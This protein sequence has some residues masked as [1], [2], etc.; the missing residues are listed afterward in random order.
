MSLELKPA[1]PRQ[2]FLST[3][4]VIAILAFVKFA[5]HLITADR[6]G[7]FRDEL[8][9][10]ACADHLSWGYVDHP[11]LI[12]FV[13]WFSAHVFGTSLLGIRFL[14]AVAGGL[15]VW[16]T[17]A[18]AK[19]LGGNRFA[20]CFAAFA[21]IP[22]PI[23]LMLNHWL[24]MNAFEPLVWMTMLWLA[25]RM[26]SRNEP[27]Y[28]LLI[29]ALCGLGLENK[30]SMLL[31][32]AALVFGL[33]VTPE[34]QIFRSRWFPVGAAV[35]F[36]LFL[37]NLLW[38]IHHDFPFLEFERRSRMSLG[39]IERAPLAFIADQA[40]MMN[41]LLTP[42]WLGG[43]SWLLLSKPASKYRFLAWTFISIFAV[44]LVLKAKNYYV[45]PAYPV[46]FAAGAVAFEKTTEVAARWVRGI[47]VGLVL[48]AGSVL[49]PFVLPVLPVNDF[50]AYQRVFGG[51][52]PIR[53]EKNS[54]SLLPQQFADEFGWEEMVR[55]TAL[56]PISKLHTEAD[57]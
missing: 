54:R 44:L 29:G 11:P 22:A 53:L 46:L 10:L 8:Y 9:Y 21:I 39:R 40:L 41:P 17:A 13:T 19:E 16:V 52:T 5:L 6:Y 3:P 50:L 7:I 27:R 47:Y 12:A 26:L 51:F 31:L 33:F 34:R 45:S 4:A 30:Y 23:Y 48:A 28:W 15:L 1:D 56:E 37:P 24:T 32:A 25:L 14:P 36:V 35:A 20:Q 49:A 42:L 43:L 55:K 2:P 38:L 57:S 18:I